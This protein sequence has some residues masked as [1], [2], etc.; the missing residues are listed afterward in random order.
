MA[1][2]VISYEIAKA[3]WEKEITTYFFDQSKTMWAKPVHEEKPFLTT[4]DIQIAGKLEIIPAPTF[5]ELLTLIP[6]RYP[7]GNDPNPCLDLQCSW[8]EG[9]DKKM[10]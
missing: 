7:S 3:L 8:R 9:P 5:N 6:K 4:F 1:D 10:I 2:E